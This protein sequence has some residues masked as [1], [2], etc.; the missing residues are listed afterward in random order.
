M[1]EDSVKKD[2]LAGIAERA[3]HPHTM[4]QKGEV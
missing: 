1:K 4:A 2:A 3:A